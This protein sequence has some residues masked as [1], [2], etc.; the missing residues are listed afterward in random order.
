MGSNSVLNSHT[1]LHESSTPGFVEIQLTPLQT[2][3]IL[4][5]NTSPGIL[6]M[7]RGYNGEDDQ[8]TEL[9]WEDDADLDF[10]DQASYPEFQLWVTF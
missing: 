3:A 5:H 7:C 2:R 8:F 9:V 10:E 6:V 4:K 1:A